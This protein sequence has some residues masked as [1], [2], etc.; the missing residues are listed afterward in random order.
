MRKLLCLGVALAF[1]SAI[2]PGCASVDQTARDNPNTTIGAGAGV[3]VG[4]VVGGLIGGKRGALIGGLLGGLA[5]GAVGHY[6]DQQEKDRLQTSR[7][8]RYSPAQGA[9]I[10]IET[11]RVN[12]AALSPGETVN[13]NLT[14]AVLT[15]TA[16]TQVL[17]RETRE[18]LLNGNSVGKTSIEISREG[19]TWKSTVPITL[20]ANA[21]PGK[22]LVIASIDSRTAG[23]DRRETSFQVSR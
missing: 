11:V 22:Y 7:D 17:V 9:R 23:T 16:D 6:L 1:L 14:Y 8:Y 5:G 4:A 13:I 21:A 20:P 18:I 3:L 2:L 15:P 19:G 10:K 12:P